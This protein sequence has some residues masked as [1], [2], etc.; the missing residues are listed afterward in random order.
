[1]EGGRA[2]L[3]RLSGGALIVSL[4]QATASAV[5]FGASHA[6]PFAF[7]SPSTCNILSTPADESL[8]TPV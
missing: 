3:S 5:G 6:P 4:L 2:V 7:A 8:T 1:M